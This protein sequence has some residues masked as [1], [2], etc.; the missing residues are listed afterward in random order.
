MFEDGFPK[1]FRKDVQLVCNKITIKT[2]NN[3]TIGQSEQKFS[4]MLLNNEI[5][6][7]PYRI[8]YIDNFK[9]VDKD[10]TPIQEIIYHC[11]FS[12]CCDGF[13]REKHIKA[14]L[15]IETP[16]WAL[17]Y[18]IK[19]CDEYVVEILELVY[20]YLKDIDTTKYKKICK[21]NLPLFI[22]GHSRMIS[23][24]NEFYRNRYFKYSQY[25]GKRLYKECFGY[26]RSMEKSSH[27]D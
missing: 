23:Y 1:R 20:N 5:I 21:K 2:Y 16:D 11:I 15:E 25:I 4:W 18:I 17:P 22:Y 27:F 24:W 8:Y 3:S 26:T 6:T 19:V 9:N 7:F 13:I 12:R 14:L 10:F